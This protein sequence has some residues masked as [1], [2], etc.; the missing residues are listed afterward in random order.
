MSQMIR[1]IH[2]LGCG[3]KTVHEYCPQ[4][5]P[6][7]LMEG[8]Y[9]KDGADICKHVTCW[10][11]P[12]AEHIMIACKYCNL[13]CKHVEQTFIEHHLLGTNESILECLNVSKT[14]TND[15]YCLILN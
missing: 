14:M 1:A 13:W 3:M 15:I 5:V 9:C 11:C 10:R 6:I 8:F 4:A 12:H 7:F 2:G